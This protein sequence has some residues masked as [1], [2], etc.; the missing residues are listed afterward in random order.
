MLSADDGAS[1]DYVSRTRSASGS[2]YFEM[3]MWETIQHC[4]DTKV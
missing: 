3:M 4:E 2:S 1:D